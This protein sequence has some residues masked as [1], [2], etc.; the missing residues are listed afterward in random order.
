MFPLAI[1]TGNTVV[2]KPSERDPGAM[3]LIASYCHEIGLPPGVLNVVHGKKDTVNF[4]CDHPSIKAISFVGS[5]AAGNYIF[6]R[7]SAS[8]KRVQVLYLLGQ[9]GR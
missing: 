9:L 8:R 3:M 5:D 1:V 4:I 2:M 6:Q 7:G